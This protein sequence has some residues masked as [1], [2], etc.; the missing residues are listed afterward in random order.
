M[1]GLTGAEVGQRIVE[2]GVLALI[3]QPT[4]KVL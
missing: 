4:I 2:A 3:D 1:Q